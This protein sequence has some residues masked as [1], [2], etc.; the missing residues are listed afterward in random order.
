MIRRLLSLLILILVGIGGYFLW[1]TYL[2]GDPVQLYFST[3]DGMNLVI[4]ERIVRGDRMKAAMEELIRGPHRSDLSAT[5]PEGVAL[6][7]IKLDQGLCIVNFNENLV[8]N[9]WGG[10]TGELLTVY[11]IV[12]TLCQFP[13]VERVQL[14]IEG[15]KVE[16]LAGHLTLNESLEADPELVK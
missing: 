14:L 6:L 3:K 12:N 8:K 16:T 2:S 13:G 9:H 5:I 1:T 15:Q 11:S 10:S 7:S 4:E